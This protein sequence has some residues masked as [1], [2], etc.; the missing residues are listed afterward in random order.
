[1]ARLVGCANKKKKNC[2]MSLAQRR[3]RRRSFF[4]TES[5]MLESESD[6]RLLLASFANTKFLPNILRS[7]SLLR[8]SVFRRLPVSYES[9]AGSPF[10]LSLCVLREFSGQYS[11]FWNLKLHKI[12]RKF[13][14]FRIYKMLETI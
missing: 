10:T 3:L 4:F 2:K 9:I 7:R 13:L 8:A 11:E 1:M 5:L 12:I 6:K 14:S